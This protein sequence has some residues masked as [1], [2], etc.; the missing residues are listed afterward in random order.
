MGSVKP[1]KN[2]GEIQTEEGHAFYCSGEDNEHANGVGFLVHKSIKNTVV[3]RQPISSW[4]MTIRLRANSFNITVVQVHA[5]TSAYDDEHTENFYKKLQDGTDKVDNKDILIIHRSKQSSSLP[6]FK[7][8]PIFS[9]V[10]N[11]SRTVCG[12]HVYRIT[13]VLR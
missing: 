2:A 4:L 5:P 1:G 6:S 8:T 9:A 3:G 10:Y 11:T 7:T 13:T 12:V